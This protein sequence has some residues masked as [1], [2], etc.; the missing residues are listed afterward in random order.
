[1]LTIQIKDWNNKT[2]AVINDIFSLQVEDEIN[3]WWKLKIKVP[4]EK[5]MQKESI[6]KWYRIVVNYWIKIL[7]TIK[8]FEGYITDVVVKNANIEIQAENRFSYLQNRIIRSD[9]SY[10]DTAIKDVISEIFTE[11]NN[12]FNL[13]ISLWLNDC[14]TTITRD[15]NKWTNFYDILKYCR[16]AETEL[17][18]RVIDWVLEVSKNTGDILEWVWEYDSSNTRATNIWDWS[19]KDSMDNFYS[20]LMNDEW[21]ISNSDFHNETNLMFEKYEK[22]IALT[23]PVEEAIPSVNISRDTD[24]RDFNIG[25]RKHIRI[26]TGY[27]RLP[28]E[29]LWVIQSRKITINASQ[30][31]KAEIKVSEKYKQDTNILDLILSNLRKK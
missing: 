28:L 3:K 22:D 15:F 17:I 8:L 13:P 1:M 27:E 5:R 4:V 21:N 2:Y 24:W 19:L 25:D 23:L 30:W 26:N 14:D 29:Y 9:K 16:E 11:L 6:K 10:T 7:Q 12:T 20:Y 18:V 31:L